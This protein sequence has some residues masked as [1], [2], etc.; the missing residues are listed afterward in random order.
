MSL[1]RP[2]DISDAVLVTHRTCLDGA[3][4]AIVFLRAGGRRE[5]IRFVPAGMLENF[6]KKD[7]VFAGD[8]FI[9][10]ADIGLNVPK[11]ATRIDKRGNCVLLDHHKTSAHLADR[12]WAGVDMDAC[13]TEL[14]RRYLGDDIGPEHT[15][16]CETLARVIDD[17][18]R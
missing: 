14:L 8:E 5:N 2:K 17:H 15:V 12:P 9:I 4:C 11:Y 3:G 7:P 1:P 6:V 13:G 16:T 10:F 18:D